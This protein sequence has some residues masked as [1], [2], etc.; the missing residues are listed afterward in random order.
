MIF[1]FVNMSDKLSYSSE[2]DITSSSEPDITSILRGS[3][4]YQSIEEVK[5][6]FKMH[7]GDNCPELILSPY[8]TLTFAGHPRQGLMYEKEGLFYITEFPESFLKNLSA[9]T[10]D[11]RVSYFSGKVETVFGGSFC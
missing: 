1:L 6:A 7:L 2:Q 5:G 10:L 9:K 4:P 3:G 8:N 11:T